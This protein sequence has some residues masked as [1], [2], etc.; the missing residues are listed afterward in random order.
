MKPDSTQFVVRAELLAPAVPVV[1]PMLA[2][3]G[4]PSGTPRPPMDVPLEAAPVAKGGGSLSQETWPNRRL[5]LEQRIAKLEH[6]IAIRSRH[7]VPNP[8]LTVDDAED[9]LDAL[10]SA[11]EWWLMRD[12]REQ[13]R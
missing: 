10:Y 9:Q 5:R 3:K 4:N 2:R 12:V 8:R 7:P 1:K 11:R 13:L 6:F